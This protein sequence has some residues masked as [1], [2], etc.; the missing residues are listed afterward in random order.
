MEW[1]K[2]EKKNP[3][4]RQFHKMVKQTQ[5]I[6]QQIAWVCLTILWDWRLKG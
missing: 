2:S 3:F 5:T 4:K 1:G 6:R